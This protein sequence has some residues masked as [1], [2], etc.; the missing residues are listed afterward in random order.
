[1]KPFN[2]FTKVLTGLCLK[3][4][5]PVLENLINLCLS[6]LQICTENGFPDL[7]ILGC[8]VYC[9]EVAHLVN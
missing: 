2:V 7:K 6:Q 5:K 4:R 9:G 1:M 8:C 3:E